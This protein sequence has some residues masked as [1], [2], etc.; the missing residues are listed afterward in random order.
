VLVLGGG[1]GSTVPSVPVSTADL[2]PT[3]LSALGVGTNGL[4]G[5]PLLSL[6]ESAPGDRTVFSQT[7]GEGADDGVRRF[8]VRDR[9]D[10]CFLERDLSD[11]S[12]R[13]EDGDGSRE[14]STALREY[15]RDRIGFGDATTDAGETEAVSDR[16]EALGYKE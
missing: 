2:V 1:V 14:L 15:S 6:A 3:V 8:A 12:I 7:R 11:G 9:G 5:E 4:P 16:L 10:A 13:S